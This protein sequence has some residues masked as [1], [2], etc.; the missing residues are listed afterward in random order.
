MVAACWEAEITSTGRDT[1]LGRTRA[2]RVR[3]ELLGSADRDA[4]LLDLALDRVCR[5]ARAVVN[6][7][8]LGAARGQTEALLIPLSD[9][10]F[11]IAVDPTPPGGW[12][13]VDR[14]LR[15]ELARH[16]LRFRVGHE[17]GHTFFYA[18]GRG[19]PR[20]AVADNAAQE[21]FCDEFARALLVPYG[22]AARVRCDAIGLLALHREYDVSV[23]VAARALAASHPKARIQVWWQ[24]DGKQIRLQFASGHS[25]A[26]ADVAHRLA[27]EGDPRAT[28]LS[29]RRQVVLVDSVPAR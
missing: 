6:R 25:P 16:R 5:S 28:W 10:R 22:V 11:A 17:L 8:R 23:H 13:G 7:E 2:E 15:T 20:R 29:G 14:A 4:P 1:L 19:E 18:R 9:D 12:R 24:P 21:A 27:E 26:T 3:E